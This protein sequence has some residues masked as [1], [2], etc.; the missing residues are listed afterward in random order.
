M[1]FAMH[2]VG[3]TYAHKGAMND[4]HN[5]WIWSEEAD[6]EHSVRFKYAKKA[7]SKVLAIWNG[8]CRPSFEEYDNPG[9]TN[10]FRLQHLYQFSECSD[11]G[12]NFNF[13]S[14]NIRKLSFG[15]Y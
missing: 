7:C 10:L 11:N 6:D 4:G 2:V 12:I 9:H 13:Y 15:D 1:G 3:D 14:N 8:N 5:N